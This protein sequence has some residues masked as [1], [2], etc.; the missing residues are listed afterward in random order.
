MNEIRDSIDRFHI[1]YEEDRIWNKTSWLGVPC[2]KLPFDAFV[3]QE[4]IF[5]L[6]PDWI[7][8]TGTGKGG[9]AMFYASICEL[10]HKGNII[11]VDIENINRDDIR[12]HKWS[13]RINFLKGSSIDIKIL[14]RIKDIIGYSKN[15]M[16]ILDSWHTKDHVYRE[17][18]LYSRLVPVGGYMIVEDSHANGNPVPWKWN[19]E[20]PMGAI[21]MWMN[22]YGDKWEIDKECEK[23]LMTF[24]PRGYLRRIKNGD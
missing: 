7:I 12:N 14:N 9:S 10:M 4:L 22:G 21:N 19:D 20:G 13:N 3:I 17:M 24:N 23:H 16:V 18:L 8:E 6:K 1:K 2:W 5:K 11:T 15:N